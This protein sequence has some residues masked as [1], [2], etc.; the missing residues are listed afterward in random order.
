[1]A[2][3][4]RFQFVF[5]LVISALTIS[6]ISMSY[7]QSFT[8]IHNFTG[9][10]DGGTPLAGLTIDRAGNLYGTTVYGGNNQDHCFG[11]GCGTVFKLARRG[12]GWVLTPIY[13]FQGGSDGVEPCSPIT[14]GPNGTLYGTTAEGGQGTCQVGGCGGNRFAGCGTVFNLTPATHASGNALG[15]WNETVLYR[16]SGGSDGAYPQGQISFDSG[17]NLYGTA[18]SGGT[19]GGTCGTLGCGTVYQLMGRAQVGHSMWFTAFH[20]PMTELHRKAA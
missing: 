17:G 11:I 16:F 19:L 18:V 4:A 1:M 12:S 9:G 6:S 14:I 7:A 13:T 10:P 20:P 8:V 15:A 3:P 2:H 5:C